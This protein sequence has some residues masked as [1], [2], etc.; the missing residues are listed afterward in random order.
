MGSERI[1]FEKL[2]WE[3]SDYLECVAGGHLYTIIFAVAKSGK[4]SPFNQFAGK[5]PSQV[6]EMSTP[7]KR[8]V[9]ANLM[10]CDINAF[11][12]RDNFICDREYDRAIA[13]PNQIKN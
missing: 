2:R 7:T 11:D 6:N 12:V 13:L 5:C 4:V 10:K 9:R 8:N 1:R 3:C